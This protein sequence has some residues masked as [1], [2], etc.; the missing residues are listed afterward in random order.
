M[1]SRKRVFV[2]NPFDAEIL[3]CRNCMWISV[4]A[5]RQY[6]IVV[7]GLNCCRERLSPSLQAPWNITWLTGR[8][9]KNGE[10]LVLDP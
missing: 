3:V 1:E 9:I 7:S 10:Q 2:E 4:V 6:R 5:V 8:K